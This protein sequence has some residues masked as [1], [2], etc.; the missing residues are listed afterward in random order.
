MKNDKN[1]TQTISYRVT[2]EIWQQAEER[3]AQENKSVN[4]WCRDIVVQTLRHDYGLP[5]GMQVLLK[6]FYALQQLLKHVF[7]LQSKNELNEDALLTLVF[8]NEQ[9]R[10]LILQKYFAKQSIF[11]TAL[12]AENLSSGEL[13]DADIDLERELE[14]I[15]LAAP[16]SKTEGKVEEPSATKFYPRTAMADDSLLDLA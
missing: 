7:Y 6:E 16:F 10:H 11:E 14:E 8:D 1:L 4:E 3:A 9:E 12:P 2:E 5:P 13:P 15:D